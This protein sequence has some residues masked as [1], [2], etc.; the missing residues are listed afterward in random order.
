MEGRNEHGKPFAGIERRRRYVLG[1]EW[2]VEVVVSE[3]KRGSSCVIKAPTVLFNWLL[4]NFI[5]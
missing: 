3:N 4:M 1:R 5:T 2:L